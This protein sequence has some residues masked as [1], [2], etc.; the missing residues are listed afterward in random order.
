MNSKSIEAIKFFQDKPPPFLA[1]I[2]PLLKPIKIDVNQYLY[3]KGDPA[4]EST[5]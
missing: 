1:A 4:N 3:M 5:L 2:L